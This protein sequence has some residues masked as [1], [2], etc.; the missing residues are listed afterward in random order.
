MGICVGLMFFRW[1]VC[2]ARKLPVAPVSAIAVLGDNVDGAGGPSCFCDELFADLFTFTALSQKRRLGFRQF[3][4]VSGVRTTHL[5]FCPIQIQL[6]P[7]MGLSNV[8]SLLWFLWG[9]LQLRLV[10]PV[11]RERPWLWHH[12]YCVR[13]ILTTPGSVLGA[14]FSGSNFYLSKHLTFSLV[15]LFAAC[16]TGHPSR[17][18]KKTLGGY[19]RRNSVHCVCG[20]NNCRNMTKRNPRASWWEHHPR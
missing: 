20:S 6:A 12:P 13:P 9:F 14:S 10:C 18:V 11:L 2:K 5:Y 15:V 4:S 3:Q 8:A 16:D 19:T 7:P 17:C 1:G